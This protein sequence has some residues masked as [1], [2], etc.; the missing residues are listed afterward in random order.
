M[1]SHGSD[2]PLLS[3]VIANLLLSVA[4]EAGLALIRSAHSPNVRERRD[5]STA[6]LDP[7]GQVVAQA[8]FIPMH[9]GSML[10]LIGEVLQRFPA[11]SLRPGDGFLANDPYNGGGSHLPDITVVA[12]AFHNGELV[13]WVSNIA[14][15]ADVG[16]MV[17]GASRRRAPPSTMRDC[18]SLRSRSGQSWVSATRWSSLFCSILGPL[19]SGWETSRHKWPPLT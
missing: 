16:G 4:E 14:H 7:R 15:H 19:R 8:P 10:G 2:D 12:P 17:P 1:K 6:I 13:A 18:G 11:D 9:L 3:E 5:C